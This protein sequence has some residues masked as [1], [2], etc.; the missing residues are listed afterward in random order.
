MY[1]NSITGAR[2]RA[3]FMALCW[4]ADEVDFFLMYLIFPAALWPWGRRE[5]SMTLHLYAFE[6]VVVLTEDL[7]ILFFYLH[8]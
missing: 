8:P 5:W 6:H 4:K 2:G 7:G 1:F 3:I